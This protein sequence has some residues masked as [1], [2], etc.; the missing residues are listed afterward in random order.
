MGDQA[1]PHTALFQI[2]NVCFASGHLPLR[3]PDYGNA[4]LGGLGELCRA[5]QRFL[6]VNAVGH[7]GRI[8]QSVLPRKNSVMQVFWDEATQNTDRESDFSGCFPLS[9][10]C[11]SYAMVCALGEKTY[12]NPGGVAVGSKR[13]LCDTRPF[14]WKCSGTSFGDCA[15]GRHLPWQARALVF[16]REGIALQDTCCS[17]NGTGRKME[18]A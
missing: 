13:N 10:K 15:C 3:R 2:G 4:A 6:P 12:L 18:P 17:R 7:R 14:R 1:R 9:K 16:H 5:D 11:G 8:T